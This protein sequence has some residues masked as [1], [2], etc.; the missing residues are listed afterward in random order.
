MTK[1]EQ[2]KTELAKKDATQAHKQKRAENQELLDLV[3]GLVCQ[4]YS[5]V[6]LHYREKIQFSIE[7]VQ[8]LAGKDKEFYSDDEK[9][10][11]AKW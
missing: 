10:K 4:D 5:N 6:L 9:K 2:L 7:K 1:I 11:F 3:L 8:A